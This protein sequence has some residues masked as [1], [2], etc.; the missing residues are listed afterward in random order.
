MLYWHTIFNHFLTQIAWCDDMTE[1]MVV[2]DHATDDVL[3]TK[4]GLES[5]FERKVNFMFQG[6]KCSVC[7]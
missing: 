4:D 2:R 6:S 7:I 1:R 3:E 5:H